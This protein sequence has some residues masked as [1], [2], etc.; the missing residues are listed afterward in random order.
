MFFFFCFI[1]EIAELKRLAVQSQDELRQNLQGAGRVVAELGDLVT[2]YK[3][4]GVTVMGVFLY[5]TNL[6]IGRIF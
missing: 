5:A 1:D 2:Q 4:V 3:I 6:V